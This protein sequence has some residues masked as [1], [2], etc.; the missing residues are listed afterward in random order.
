M[1]TEEAIGETRDSIDV[2]ED[3]WP[4]QKHRSKGHRSGGIP[5]NGDHRCWPES[6]DQSN[7]TDNSAC[8]AADSNE[9]GHACRGP[10]RTA[11]SASGEKDQ[12]DAGVGQKLSLLASL[13][14]HEAELTLLSP[15]VDE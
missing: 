14:A 15:P 7:R 11:N 9:V 10:Q 8:D 12:L 3:K 2:H 6:S 5:S 13:R 1:A 4:M